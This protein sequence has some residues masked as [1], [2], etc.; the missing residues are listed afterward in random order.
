MRIRID[1]AGIITYYFCLF[2]INV[3]R[4]VLITLKRKSKIFC[5]IHKK[6]SVLESLYNKVGDFINTSTTGAFL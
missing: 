6:I 1:H 2:I 5:N 3:E 4:L